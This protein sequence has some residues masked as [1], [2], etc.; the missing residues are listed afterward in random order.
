LKPRPADHEAHAPDTRSE[1]NL[2]VE[3][4]E[5]ALRDAVG[6]KEGQEPAWYRIDALDWLNSPNEMFQ[7]CRWLLRLIGVNP[8]WAQQHRNWPQERLTYAAERLDKML[9]SLRAVR[10]AEARIENQE[11][12]AETGRFIA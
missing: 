7:S 2:W 11:R 6:G 3:V 8:D 4:F 12:D 1:V 10:A 5:R 9:A